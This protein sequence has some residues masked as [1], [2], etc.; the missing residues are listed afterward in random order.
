MQLA[1]EKSYK[2]IET[3][4]FDI[5]DENMMKTFNTVIEQAGY[6]DRVEIG[7]LFIETEFSAKNAF[8]ATIKSTAFG[9]ASY[10]NNTIKLI[11]I[12]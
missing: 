7:D 12:R 5:Y 2:H 1:L 11:T 8:N 6:S 10:K 4:Y 3:S 9:I